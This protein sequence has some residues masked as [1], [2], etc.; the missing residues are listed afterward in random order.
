MFAHDSQHLVGQNTDYPYQPITGSRNHRIFVQPHE[1]V[2]RS[3][4]PR[5]TVAAIVPS[6]PG[7]EAQNAALGA[8]HDLT[9]LLY[10]DDAQELVFG[11]LGPRFQLRKA[12][13]EIE[14]ENSFCRSRRK[15]RVN[16]P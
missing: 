8:A 12:R 5:E 9:P 14:V 15:W 7:V 11:V 1:G 4:V 10:G 6:T 13:T 16:I 2:H 3:G